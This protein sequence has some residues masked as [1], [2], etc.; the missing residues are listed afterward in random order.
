M[1]P[2]E[3]ERLLQEQTEPSSSCESEEGKQENMEKV[4]SLISDFYLDLPESL[5]F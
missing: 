1:P 3:V 2:N 5:C 4:H